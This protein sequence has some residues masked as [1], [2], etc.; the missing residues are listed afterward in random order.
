MVTGIALD[1]RACALVT[2]YLEPSGGASGW[3]TVK[4]IPSGEKLWAARI[5][6]ARVSG[7]AYGVVV[8]ARVR[9]FVAGLRYRE[10]GRVSTVM[11][12]STRDGKRPWRKVWRE[13]GVWMSA[14]D[15]RAVSGRGRGAPAPRPLRDARTSLAGR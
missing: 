2:G 15:L 10:S 14:A 7:Q 9:P 4:V 13:D 8:D 12:R 6:K 1:R 3:R 11:A 5:S